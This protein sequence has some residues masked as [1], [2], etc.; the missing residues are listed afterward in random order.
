MGPGLTA[1]PDPEAF[2]LCGQI[3]R[4]HT[5]AP[6]CLSAAVVDLVPRVADVLMNALIDGTFAHSD[7]LMNGLMA[8]HRRDS[9]QTSPT[10]SSR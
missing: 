9:R 2:A 7:A 4:L 8:T 1:R 10:P 5:D 3:S 6:S